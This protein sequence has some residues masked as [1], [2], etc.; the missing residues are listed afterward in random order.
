MFPEARKALVL[1]WTFIVFLAAFDGQSQAQIPSQPWELSGFS[2]SDTYQVTDENVLDLNGDYVVKLLY[3]VGK[4]SRANFQKY[5]Q[6]SKDVALAKLREETQQHRFS[7]FRLEGLAKKV[8]KFNFPDAGDTGLKSCF[9]VDFE[10]TDGLKLIVVSRG[11]PTAWLKSES[12]NE[13]SS[14]Y[15]FFVA[16]RYADESAKES[17]DLRPVFVTKRPTWEPDENSAIELPAS[18]SQSYQLLAEHGVDVGKIDYVRLQNNRRLGKLDN[19]SFFQIINATQEIKTSEI[20][21]QSLSFVQL[22]TKPDDYFGHGIGI[23][24]RVRRCFRV[25]IET[26]EVREQ[27][28]IDH[29]Y[30]LDMFYPL[31]DQKVDIKN[32]EGKVVKVYEDRYPLTVC[33]AKLPEGMTPDDIANHSVKINGFFYRFWSY[34]TASSEQAG[35]QAQTS[36]LIIGLVDE[37]D[38]SSTGGMDFV[39]AGLLLATMLGAIAMVWFFRRGDKERDL[40]T[41]KRAALP[42]EVDVSGFGEE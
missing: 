15:G 27:Y 33:A 40:L 42:D 32:R 38:S 5:S 3:R 16:Q 6:L 39:V 36:P 12:L 2:E 21:D 13:H 30:E 22:L 7:V 8:E 37:I 4:T 20:P 35:M 41:K 28:G 18:L 25:N 23:K 34:Q 24:G 26:A 29:Y 10:T 17:G 1:I 19:E 31:G 14:L 11:V 9:K